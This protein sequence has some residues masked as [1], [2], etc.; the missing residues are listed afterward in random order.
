MKRFTKILLV[1]LALSIFSAIPVSATAN[2][3][4]SAITNAQVSPRASDGVQIQPFTTLRVN[5]NN[6]SFFSYR[7]NAQ[8]IFD[9]TGVA[10]GVVHNGATVRDWG[11]RYD[12]VRNGHWY[13]FVT[14][15]GGGNAANG[16]VGR[17]G[18]I[19]FADIG[20]A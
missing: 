6:A 12:Q 14:I 2:V 11:Y 1:V 8:G 5:R 10:L 16:N 17:N 4:E 3:S 19:R 18:F 20:L 9:H 13:A 15:T 7:R